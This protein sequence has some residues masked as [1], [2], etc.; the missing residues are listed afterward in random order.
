MGFR[1]YRYTKGVLN[2]EVLPYVFVRLFRFLALFLH[3]LSI[4]NSCFDGDKGYNSSFSKVPSL[5]VQGN[6]V[7]ERAVSDRVH[8]WVLPILVL[9]KF[10]HRC[11]RT[12]STTVGGIG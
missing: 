8:K 6:L 1:F 12:P 9:E 7:F 10:C 4:S 11:F 3:R 2:L 5:S